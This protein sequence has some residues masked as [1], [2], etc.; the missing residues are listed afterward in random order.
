MLPILIMAQALSYVGWA[1]TRCE[2][3]GEMTPLIIDIACELAQRLLGSV[4]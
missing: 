4:K 2:T 1:H 3:A